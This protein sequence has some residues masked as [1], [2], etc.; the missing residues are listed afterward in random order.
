MEVVKYAEENDFSLLG[1]S[2]EVYEINNRHTMM[3]EQYLTE[4]PIRV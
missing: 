1:E 3:S 2:F 4:I